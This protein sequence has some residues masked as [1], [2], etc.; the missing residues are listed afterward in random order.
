VAVTATHAGPIVLT[1]FF[2]SP[3]HVEV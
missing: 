2:K 3:C 1:W